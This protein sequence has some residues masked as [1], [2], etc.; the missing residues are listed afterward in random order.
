M[1]VGT[2]FNQMENIGSI[3][4]D[5]RSSKRLTSCEH[6]EGLRTL[7][8]SLNV[9]LSSVDVHSPDVMGI[10]PFDTKARS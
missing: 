5:K 6:L 10:R 8:P 2:T 1:E 4:G 7:V 9:L 3:D